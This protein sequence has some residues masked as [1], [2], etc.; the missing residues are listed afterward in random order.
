MGGG[1]GGGISKTKDEVSFLW[2]Q[3]EYLVI[4]LG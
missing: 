4:I 2:L 3:D 1:G